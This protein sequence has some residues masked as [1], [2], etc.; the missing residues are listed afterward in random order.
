MTEEVEPRVFALPFKSITMS[1]RRLMVTKFGVNWDA[2]EVE[3][4][5]IPKPADADNPT[6]SEQIAAAKVFTRIVGPVEKF[7]LLYIAVKREE[8]AATEAKIEAKADSGEWVLSFTDPLDDVEG[9]VPLA[10]PNATTSS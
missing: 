2:V 7:A 3:M 9:G 10:P 8:P 5:D 1:E 4:V 6:Q